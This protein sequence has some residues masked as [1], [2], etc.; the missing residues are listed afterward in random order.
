M[1]RVRLAGSLALESDGRAIPLPP[2][3]RAR[4][5]LAYLAAHPGPH[6]RGEL[7]ARFWPDVLDESARTSLRAALSELRRALGPEAERLVATRE[8]VALDGAW[9]D[10]RESA[11]LL[12]AGRVDDAAAVCDGELLQGMD[13][14][15]VFEL[16][17]EHEDRLRA[18]GADRAAAAIGSPAV[19]EREELF[20]GRTGELARLHE[21][22][23]FVRDRRARRLLLLAGEPGVGKTRLALRFACEA[24]DATVLI[25]RC[26]EDPLA[27]F[28]PFT[29]VLR[30]VGP[31]A[32]RA[33]A[34]SGEL[35]RLLGGARR[36]PDDD[37]GARHRLFAAVDDVLTGIAERR[38]LVLILD[39]LHWADRPT[40]LLLS[41]V[42][43]GGRPAPLLVL[44]T[45]RDTE[46]GRR[47]PLA[48]ALADLRR[49]G[50]AERIGLRGLAPG[51][52][53]ELATAWLGA[54]TAARVAGTV[55][56]RTGGNAFFVEEVLRGLA[57]DDASVPE[58]V[59]HAVGARLA[60]LSPEADELLAVAAVLGLVVDAE[61]LASVAGRPAA[62]VEPLLDELFEA[63]LLLAR[64]GRSLEFPHALVR[65]AVDRD[66][67][68]LRRARLHRAA[69]AALIARGEER[70]LAEIAHHLSEA[71]DDRAPDYLRRAGEEA[72]A[73][74]AYEEAAAQ[75]ERA[76]E[77]TPDSGPL[78]L[79]RGDA[80]L[81]A[82]EPAAARGCFELAASLA[83]RAGDPV[84]LG[85]AA[86][87]HAGLGIS[88][89]DLDAR[90]I[91]LLEEALAALGDREPVLRSELLARLAVEL[92]YAPSRD[93]SE[94]LSS[95]AV[96]VARRAGD[97]RAVAA[98]LNARHVALWRPDRLA[99]RL[100]A[101]DEM[102]AVADEP[103]V[104][105]QAR[106]WRVVDLFEALEMDEWRAEVARHGELA[107]RLRMPTYTWYTPLWAAVDA[108]HAGRWD[109]AAALGDRARE[110]GRRA[111]D[112]NADLFAEMLRFD[113]V[114]MRGNWEALDLE[115]LLE[116]IANSPAGMAWRASYAWMLAATG[117]SDAAREQYAI[118]AADDF[119]ALPFDT[120]W[121]SGMGE[122]ASACIELGDPGLARPLYDRLLPYA[123]RALTAGRAISSY[124]ST[125]RLLGSL[126]AILGRDDEATTRLEE[127]VRRN[128]A[129][130][131]TVW[132]DH[133]RRALG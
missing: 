56:A 124:G 131:F 44:G 54:E 77:A 16:R 31:A 94:A 53:G 6:A 41:F 95:Q 84:L 80:L 66:L 76:L 28:E 22:W 1:L 103:H 57:D 129:A 83:R 75:F 64:E 73:M 26:S 133:A 113:E 45:Y 106:N 118:V 100:A 14:E 127:A 19:L 37:A 38:P 130:G 10:L 48:A 91:A 63:R 34:G 116:R 89:I 12:E 58:S 32:A 62:E 24:D 111:G 107:A 99:E 42:L 110:E 85:R 93:R 104:E 86:L 88:I 78:L 52:V 25:G 36:G 43:R 46:V 92:Y 82:G 65:E 11:A 5:L 21:A 39:D 2:S 119:A 105:L 51:E 79:A 59:R 115:L 29:D 123:D 102:L 108:V 121:P 67:N 8:T 18:A 90:A 98:A 40:L 132:A 15:W 81:R 120:N 61:L 27:A 69:A 101:A 122:L 114:I 23:R 125:Q 17:R 87:G 72:L 4:A 47:T 126:A 50:G 109:E 70:H 35:D 60:R 71:A 117:Q 96:A 7:A 112:R 97:R 55:H 9:V 30:H 128:E 49:D 20:V 68:P 3:R 13:D 74:L 33:L